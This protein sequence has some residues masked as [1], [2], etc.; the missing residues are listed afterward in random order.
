VEVR[1]GQAVGEPRVVHTGF[2][3]TLVGFTASGALHYTQSVGGGNYHYVLPR[4]PSAA[5][6]PLSFPGLSS[7]WSPDGRSIAFV[8]GNSGRELDLIVRDVE[9]GEE[10]SYRHEG[11]GVQSPRWMPDGSAVLVIV[12]EQ[13]DGRARATFQIV[14]LRTGNFRRLFDR[15]AHGRSRTGVGAVSRDGKTLYLGVRATENSPV[16]AI[17]GVDLGTGE[18]RHVTDFSSA[19]GSSGFGIAVSP[20]GSTLAVTAWTKPYAA[21]RLF[22]VG[23]DGSNY[24]EVW[25]PF[26]TGWLGD[27]TRWTPDGGT[28]L[29]LAFDARKNW[30]IMRVPVAG[31]PAQPD[32]LDFDTL[33]PLLGEI[34]MWPG[35]F[36]NIDLS[37]DG[38]KLVAST[39]T[40][41][42]HE[43]WTLDG[44]SSF[45]SSR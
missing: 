28:L 35:N 22:T 43:L 14:D 21:A 24:R 4:N 10:R 6:R 1:G 34:R 16:T 15:D 45:I 42:K 20:D 33:T 40:F 12:N 31:G 13:V 27:T 9:T 26:E 8:R 44:V 39:L 19:A 3:G 23:V 36:N 25:G 37:P 32:G 29:F 18:E 41:S 17:V 30:R 11:I 7:S 5:D 38:S 2:D